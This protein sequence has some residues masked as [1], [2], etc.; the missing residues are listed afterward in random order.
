MFAYDNYARFREQKQADLAEEQLRAKSRL[1]MSD[2][3]RAMYDFYYRNL[4][5][6]HELKGD[7]VRRFEIAS[8]FVNDIWGKLNE[9]GSFYSKAA[10]AVGPD[11]S[12]GARETVKRDLDAASARLLLRF[13]AP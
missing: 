13:N 6:K 2:D 12:R 1:V 4:K 5:H 9:R 10:H 11:G 8:I 3:V 7:D